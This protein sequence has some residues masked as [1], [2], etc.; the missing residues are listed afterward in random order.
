MHKSIHTL[1]LACKVAL[2]KPLFP[3][4]NILPRVQQSCECRWY[5]KRFCNHL[6]LFMGLYHNLEIRVSKITNDPLPVKTNVPFSAFISSG[7]RWTVCYQSLIATLP[8]RALCCWDAM[9]SDPGNFLT[10]PYSYHLL[11]ILQRS[12]HCGTLKMN[13]PIDIPSENCAKP[14][15][16]F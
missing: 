5:G 12:L 4:L 14:I 1:V 2:V 3:V 11:C 13:F 6:Q 7:T 16:A 8:S 10:M 9:P 15:L